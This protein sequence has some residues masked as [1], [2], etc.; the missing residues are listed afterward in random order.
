MKDPLRTNQE[1]HKEISALK[2]KIKELEQ[3]ESERKRASEAPR[4]REEYFKTIIQNSSD[5]IFILDKL[6][7]IT[8]ASSSIVRILGYRP[9]ELIGKSTLDLIVSD[10]KPRA[11][12]DFGRALLTTEAPIPNVFRVRHKNGTERILEGIGNNLL[13]NPIVAGFVMNVHD[14]TD[15]KRAEY[16]L[17]ESEKHYRMLFSEIDEGFCIVEV[18]FDENENPI[19]YRF[20]EINPSFEKQ[21]GLIDAKGKRMRELAPKHEEHWFEIYGKIAIT[22]QPVRF[23][24]RAEQ[25]HRWYDVYAFR[26]GQPED[27]QV[28][29]LFND[30]TERKRI[31]EEGF[32][33]AEIG[34]VIGSTLDINELYELITTEIRKLIPFNSLRVN[35]CNA[36]EDTMNV[37]YVSGLDI[38]GRRAGESY[39]IQGTVLEEVIR[40]RRG[41]IVQS[42]NAEDLI[43]KFPSLIVSVR[44]GIRSIMSVPLIAH[45]D[46]IGSLV[47]RSKNPNAYTGQDLLLMERIGAQISGAI[48]NAQLFT[49]I[50]KTETSLRE[51]E[52]RF[53]SLFEQ[54]AVGVAEIEIS[55]SRFITVNRRLCEMVGRTEEELLATTFHAITHPEDIPL[56]EEKRALLS[57]GKITQYSRVKRYLRKDGESVWVNIMIS[58]LGKPGEKSGRNMIVVE[59]ITERKRVGD[60]VQLAREVLDLLNRQ[61]DTVDAIHDI[62][63]R[64]KK[65]TGF[66]AIGIRLK[67]GDDF[68]Y[69]ATNGFPEDFV[70]AERRLCAY[71]KD[72]KIVRDQQGN[73]VLEC[74]CG[75]IVCGRTDASLPFFTENGSFWTNSTTDL[76]ASTTEEDRQSR[77]RNRCNGEGYES[78][79][80]IPLKSGDEVIGLL[81]LND[82]RRNRFTLEMIH[83]F[84]GLGAS[85]G[86][87]LIR[88]QVIGKLIESEGKYRNILESIED[89]YFE[90]DVAGNL[91]FFNDSV[92]RMVGMTPAEM[93]GMNNRQYTDEENSKTLYKAFNKIFKT[94]EPLTGVCYEIIGK[95]GTKLY[96][97][98]S[99]SLIRNTSGQPIGFR[100]IMR[101]TTERKQAEQQLQDT[102]ESLRKAVGTTIQVLAYTVETRDPY[103]AGHQTRSA[104]L[105]RAVATEIGLPKEKI[106][107]IRIAGSIHDIGKLSIPA[108][109][110]SKP[111]KLSEIEFAL[112]KEHARKG[113]EMLKDVE[114]PWPLAEIIYQHH[115]RMDGSGYPRNLKGEEICIE[116]RILAV[117]DVVEAMASHRPYRP[118]FGIDVA[119]D[120][121]EKNRGIIYDKAVADAC[122]RLFREKDFQLQE[123]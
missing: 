101:N 42:E 64:I 74:M 73:P 51:S 4:E 105:A 20:L 119:L 24:N 91:T 31:E 122:L 123:A 9:D 84:E 66:E 57:A 79:A 34:Q 95:D 115:E 63:Q 36:Q 94:G 17:F 18:I 77:T 81:Q 30:I 99:V 92:C 114:S 37:T 112:I 72:G 38:P 5:I 100:G 67:E 19:D 108:E 90:V 7:T 120:E 32:V 107:A 82:H 11:I 50:R 28:A 118:G 58:S 87:A 41:I 116:A 117:A 102:L 98:S 22:G 8:Y 6:G 48:F 45:N 68:P 111:T 96:I 71:D 59:D 35:L 61:S 12:A 43:D 46:L 3:A 47:V 13:D 103:T 62:L 54:A 80:L 14:I 53:R 10:D 2:Q 23:V 26:F 106:D 85:I 65:G 86:I 52:G 70:L 29:I 97:E 44:A 1:L 27:R 15:R 78:V 113:F 25:L 93:M 110:L 60:R 109:I 16:E 69:Y 75:N 83:F 55:T 39:P 88:K 89:G 21:T 76:L 33:L 104:D 49:E 56:D 40:T 121:I